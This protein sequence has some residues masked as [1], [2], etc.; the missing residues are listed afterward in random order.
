MDYQKVP[1]QVKYTPIK[2][3][4]SHNRLTAIEHIKAS[5]WLWECKCGNTV[6]CTGTSVRRGNRKSCGCLHREK[7]TRNL[8]KR[9]KPNKEAC[10]NTLF[11]ALR[12]RAT[13][14]KIPFL[15]ERNEVDHLTQQPCHYCGA[16]SSSVQRVSFNEDELAYNGIDRVDNSKGYEL[17]NVVPCCK[18]CNQAKNSLTVD[19]FVSWVRKVNEY[20]VN[21]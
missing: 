7:T 18:L 11:L 10:K 2:I 20:F 6:K 5:M 3:G 15:L 8:K 12:A 9:K 14:R 13:R 17:T 16:L 4:E 19:E 1:K 21:P